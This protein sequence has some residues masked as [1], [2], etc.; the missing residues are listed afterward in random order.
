MV[1][2][3]LGPQ[4]R[5]A[6]PLLQKGLGLRSTLAGSSPLHPELPNGLLHGPAHARAASTPGGVP[7]TVA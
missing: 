1:A 5:R 3:R 2:H 4:V 7:I 6:E